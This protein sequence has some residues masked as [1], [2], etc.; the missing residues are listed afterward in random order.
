MSTDLS[1]NMV[2]FV[3]HHPTLR[4]DVNSPQC[5]YLCLNPIRVRGQDLEHSCCTCTSRDVKSIL[6]MVSKQSIS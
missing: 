4:G 2:L 6:E 3:V 5:A 1:S